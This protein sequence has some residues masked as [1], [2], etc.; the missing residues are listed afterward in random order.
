M[1]KLQEIRTRIHDKEGKRK[2][3]SKHFIVVPKM[4]LKILDWKKGD[5]INFHVEREDLINGCVRI[6]KRER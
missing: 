6:K 4:I 1:P 5:E 2:S 3:Y